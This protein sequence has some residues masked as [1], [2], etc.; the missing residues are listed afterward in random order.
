MPGTAHYAETAVITGGASELL[1]YTANLLNQGWRINRLTKTGSSVSVR[2][3]VTFLSW[4]EDIR[5]E[6]VGETAQTATVALSSKSAF[7]A[8]LIDWGVNRRNVERLHA[9]LLRS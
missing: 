8:T 9:E 6:I 3:K 2:T 1:D 4:G 7:K 5:V